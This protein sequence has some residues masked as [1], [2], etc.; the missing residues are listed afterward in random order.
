MTKETIFLRYR[1]IQRFLGN[2]GCYLYGAGTNGVWVLDWCKVAGIAVN[3]FID[4]NSSLV[5]T[6]VAGQMVL[7]YEE[8]VK[9]NKANTVIFVTSK[10]HSRE[11]CESKYDDCLIISFDAFF[12]IRN[13]AEYSLLEFVDAKSEYVLKKICD[14]MLLGESESIYQIAETNQYFCMAPFFNTGNETFVDFG[15]CS[16]DTIERFL[17]MHNGAYREIYA[18]E[19]GQ[20]QR[21]AI[22]HRMKRLAN[23][24]CLQEDSYHIIPA[25]VG[26]NI[27]KLYFET[28]GNIM[29]SQVVA[30]E[31]CTESV[32]QVDIETIDHFFSSIT[33]SFFKFDIEGS[34]YEALL[35]GEN[36][37]KRD[38]PKMA[39]SVYHR[40]DDLIR[41]Y[42]LIKSW[43]LEYRFSLR[44]HS[45]LLMDTTL[46]CY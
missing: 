18:F 43:D 12:F 27:G 13:I 5:G 1:E 37:I 42:N 30:M 46:Y 38:R 22:N 21:K 39:I 24:W 45:S 15:A 4:S 26:R 34:E 6:C 3:G 16:G 35:G 40:P 28:R 29:S 8:A 41:I 23:E 17:E 32:E 19:P 36:V 33:V 11:I 31:K 9:K 44:H 25:G 7:S 14:Y 2:D 20:Q 10:H